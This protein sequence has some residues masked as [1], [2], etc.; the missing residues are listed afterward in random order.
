MTDTVLLGQGYRTP[1]G[2]MMDE[3]G[4]MVPLRPQCISFE[5]TRD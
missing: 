2:A 1:H 3:C 5:V 4:A